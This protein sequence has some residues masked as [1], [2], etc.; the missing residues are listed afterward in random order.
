MSKV[1]KQSVEVDLS[2]RSL[3][4]YASVV[5]EKEEKKWTYELV[6]RLIEIVEMEYPIIYDTSSKDYKNNVIQANA[7]VKISQKLGNGISM[8]AVSQFIIIINH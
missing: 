6:G 5:K 1:N 7:R 8:C 3:R 4:K 2:R